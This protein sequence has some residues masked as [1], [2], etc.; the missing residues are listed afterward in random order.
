MARNA[1]DQ[2]ICSYENQ[3]HANFEYPDLYWPYDYTLLNYQ[4]PG[5]LQIPQI[6]S[7]YSSTEVFEQLEPI[8][9]DDFEMH[10]ENNLTSHQISLE[11]IE[12]IQHRSTC[13][14][15]SGGLTDTAASQESSLNPVPS[16]RKDQVRKKRKR[17]SPSVNI[18]SPLHTSEGIYFCPHPGCNATGF[19]KKGLLG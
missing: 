17:D 18:P 13:A 16:I 12:S 1:M 9:R 19:N 3:L 7:T 6:D 15:T 14:E 8:P 10:S 11:L 2:T 4:P 5:S